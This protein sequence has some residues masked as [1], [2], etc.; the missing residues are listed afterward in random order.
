MYRKSRFMKV[1]LCLLL[2]AV[3][4]TGLIPGTVRTASASAEKK[5]TTGDTGSEIL[6]LDA[7]TPTELT[8]TDSPYLNDVYDS[9]KKPFL[10]SEQNELGLF[11]VNQGSPTL[12][13]FDTF[14]LDLSKKDSDG[15]CWVNGINNRNAES[16][17]LIPNTQLEYYEDMVYMQSVGV[18]RDGTGR[19]EY[20]ASV[21]FRL[22]YVCVIVQ[23]TKT[24]KIWT[25]QIQEAAW[26]QD[27][28][29]GS[30]AL[31]YWVADN[32]L[33][34]TAGDYDGDGKDSIIIYV[35][36]NGDNVTLME[37]TRG[38]DGKWYGKDILDF[39]DVL[40]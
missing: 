14:N 38:T 27:T 23:S 30:E 13:R 8:E 35:C 2:S 5:E 4:L 12:N 18:D 17:A 19:K 36:G 29:I 3:M 32:Y 1:L 16:N 6:A 15:T 22:G 33:A 39:S 10:L 25:Q 26:T 9:G 24:G 11:V 34:I 40:K 37:F 28:T 20:I 7:T 21:G 31:K